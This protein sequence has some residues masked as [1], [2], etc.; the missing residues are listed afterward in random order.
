MMSMMQDISIRST[1]MIQT[2]DRMEEAMKQEL[3]QI[4]PTKKA[5]EEKIGW[6][7]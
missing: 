4:R 3:Q 7:R 2:I 6:Q 1:K 5:G